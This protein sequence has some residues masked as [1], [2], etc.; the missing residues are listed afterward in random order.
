MKVKIC[1]NIFDENCFT[2]DLSNFVD[3]Y[4]MRH[5]MKRRWRD[6]HGFI[7]TDFAAVVYLMTLDLAL[8]GE[9]LIPLYVGKTSNLLTRVQQHR[10]KAWFNHVEYMFVEQFPTNS[11]A[12]RVERELIDGLRPVFNKQVRGRKKIKTKP[13]SP[14]TTAV[15][16]MLS[17][18]QF[19]EFNG[20]DHYEWVT[21]ELP[22]MSIFPL[23]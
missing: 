5:S 10:E 18:L 1:N 22:T 4:E 15:T 11:A 2:N 8:D 17:L 21:Q 23:R 9:T 6:K 12:E 20:D 7:R 3:I 14:K 19:K 13:H 16:N